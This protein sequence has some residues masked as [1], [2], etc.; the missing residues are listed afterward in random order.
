MAEPIRT[1]Q[2][3]NAGRIL[4]V[5]RILATSRAVTDVL[6]ARDGVTLCEELADIAAELGATDQEIEDS[7]RG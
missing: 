3:I 7:F 5:I 6:W 2:E 4:A 1:S